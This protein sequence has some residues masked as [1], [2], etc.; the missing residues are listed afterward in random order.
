MIDNNIVNSI[1]ELN[2]KLLLFDRLGIFDPC[3][4]GAAD[5]SVLISQISH[6]LENVL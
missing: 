3:V 6:T 5:G 4:S 1:I 2:F